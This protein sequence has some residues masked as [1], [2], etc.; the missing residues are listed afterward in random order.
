VSNYI[1]T[2]RL[3]PD[4]V[5]VLTDGHVESDFDWRIAAPTMWLVTKNKYFTPPVG[6]MVRMA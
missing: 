1:E 4:C 6:R 3:K 5:V 2:E